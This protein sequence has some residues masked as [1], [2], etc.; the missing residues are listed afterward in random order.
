[1]EWGSVWVSRGGL[2]SLCCAGPLAGLGWALPTSQLAGSCWSLCWASKTMCFFS[3]I[4]LLDSW[5]ACRHLHPGATALHHTRAGVRN[6]REMQEEELLTPSLLPVFLPICFYVRPVWELWPSHSIGGLGWWVKHPRVL[7]LLLGC[8]VLSEPLT[9]AHLS[10]CSILALLPLQSGQF[11]ALLL[12]S[13]CSKPRIGKK[14]TN[15]L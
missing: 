5:E 9:E 2:G 4:A 12:S 6:E 1:M 13:L 8:L 10:W 14:T 11:L 15:G 7:S 3:F